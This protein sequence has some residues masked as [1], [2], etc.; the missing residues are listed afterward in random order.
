M[1][2]AQATTVINIIL[3]AAHQS[4]LFV[5][6][7]SRTYKDRWIYGTRVQEFNRRVN[8]ARKY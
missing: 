5:K 7:H 8:A 1:L 4:I 2:D 3:E 6:P